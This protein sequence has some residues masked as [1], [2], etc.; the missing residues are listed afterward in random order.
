MFTAIRRA[1]SRVSNL[2]AELLREWGV[3]DTNRRDARTRIGLRPACAASGFFQRLVGHSGNEEFPFGLV[4]G[5]ISSVRMVVHRNG[6]YPQHHPILSR[7]RFGHNRYTRMAGSVWQVA[8]R[9]S[10]F[11]LTV[12]VAVACIEKPADAQNGA[13]CIYQDGNSSGGTPQCRYATLQQCLADRLGGSS[14]APSPYPSSTESPPSTRP[15]RR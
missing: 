6:S 10:V 15:R 1:S 12:F 13:W 14:C 5:I 2:A 7:C 4:E 8:M 9:L 11:I 3:R